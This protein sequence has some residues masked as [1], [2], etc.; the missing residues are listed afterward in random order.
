MSLLL[1][2]LPAPTRDYSSR[3]PAEQS[4]A[5]DAA[6]LPASNS[7]VP[8]YGKRKGYVP[9]KDADF[10]GGGAFPEIL[11]AQYP[12]GMGRKDAAATSKTLA[13][14][15]NAEGDVQYDVILRQGKNK[16][17]AIV[18]DHTALVPKIDRIAKGEVCCGVCVNPRGTSKAFVCTPCYHSIT[19]RVWSAPMKKQ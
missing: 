15:T 4:K 14:T 1:S 5:D 17:K 10:G 16:D 12:L 9:R 7:S 18:S 19:P 3:K 8:P 2:S 11:M 13:L 6:A